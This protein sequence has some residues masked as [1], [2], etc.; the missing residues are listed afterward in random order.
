MLRNIS[1]LE[2]IISGRYL[3]FL[4]ESDTPLDHVIEGLIEFLKYAE[5]VKAK[6]I[7]EQK[8]AQ[9]KP[10]EEEPKAENVDQH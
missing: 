9:Q 5:A 6:I 4:C 8:A 7:D 1:Q 3:R 10:S 2:T